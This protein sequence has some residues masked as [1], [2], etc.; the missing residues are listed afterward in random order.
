MTKTNIH[1]ISVSQP[2]GFFD[3]S[4][5][6][7]EDNELDHFEKMLFSMSSRDIL[8]IKESLRMSEWEAK[9]D[10]EHITNH[11][12][13]KIRACDLALSTRPKKTITVDKASY[14]ACGAEERLHNFPATRK[15]DL[16]IDILE[17]EKFTIVTYDNGHLAPVL[18]TE[19]QIQK[20]LN[21]TFYWGQ[22]DFQSKEVPSV[23]VG[24]IIHVNCRFFRV[25]GVGF[26]E[27]T[28]DEVD[29]YKEI[30]ARDR[31]WSRWRESLS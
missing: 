19:D 2:D 3:D 13:H 1:I 12:R 31:T 9:H 22:N 29:K 23:S 10:H 26:E 8:S 24:D 14:D 5:S 30:P 18:N 21:L 11:Y 4:N 6:G 7:W 27:L 16:Y 15:V 25:A 28:A 20:I 17:E